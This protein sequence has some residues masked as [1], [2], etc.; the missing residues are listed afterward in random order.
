MT[1]I[2]QRV[3]ELVEEKIADRPDLF[4]VNIQMLSNGKLSV[5]LD[6]DAGISIDDCVKISRH[7]GFHLEEEDAIEQAY[8]LEVSSPGAESPFVNSRQYL[9]NIGRQV[10]IVLKDQKVLQGELLEYNEDSLK[11]ASILPTKG[12]KVIKGRKPE[13][14]D[15]EVSLSDILSTKVIISF[16]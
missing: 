8:V 10:E 14:E 15:V 6:G 2:E 4:I 5:L 9:K 3:K 12:K 1:K 16:K 7:V 11:I 13:T